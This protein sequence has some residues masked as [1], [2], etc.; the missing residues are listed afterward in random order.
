MSSALRPW[1]LLVLTLTGWHQCLA[2]KKWDYSDRRRR[3]LGRPLVPAKVRRLILRIASE[4]PSWGYKRIQGALANLG[5]RSPTR[6]SRT[7]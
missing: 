7:S 6:L 3:I 4:N 1:H 5:T 2:T